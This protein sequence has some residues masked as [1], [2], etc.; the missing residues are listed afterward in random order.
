MWVR[1]ISEVNFNGLALLKE[2]HHQFNE[3]YQQQSYRNVKL[4]KLLN[5]TLEHSATIEEYS[6]HFINLLVLIVEED[7]Q[8]LSDEMMIQI[9][10]VMSYCHGITL[11]CEKLDQVLLKQQEIIQAFIDTVKELNVGI[12]LELTKYQDFP[13]NIL[14]NIFNEI[15]SCETLHQFLTIQERFW[16]TLRTQVLDY[17]TSNEVFK[18]FILYFFTAKALI[19]FFNKLLVNKC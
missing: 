8:D 16:T 6:Q 15:L 5:E 7:N 1:T 10:M 18:L 14:T 12:I 9:G 19:D 4:T 11:F 3:F 13:V 17:Q 2:K